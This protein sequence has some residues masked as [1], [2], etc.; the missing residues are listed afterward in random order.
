MLVS[1]D[2]V[3]ET[4]LKKRSR[5]K[6]LSVKESTMLEQRYRDYIESGPVDSIV[7]D[8]ENDY[9]VSAYRNQFTALKGDL[10]C[11]FLQDV[12]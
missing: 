9:Q 5:W 6:V 11:P 10:L 4:K 8:F 2:V 12:K 3:W 7:I 1:S